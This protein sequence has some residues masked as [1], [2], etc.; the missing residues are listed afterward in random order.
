MRRGR[1]EKLPSERLAEGTFRKDL[2]ANK[3]ELKPMTRT[4][5]FIYPPEWLTPDGKIVWEENIKNC[6]PSL[7]DADVN[8]FGMFCNMMGLIQQCYKAG[9]RPS[10]DYLTETR[11]L[12]ELF[13]LCGARSRVVDN[14]ATSSS[15]N[16][17][18]NSRRRSAGWGAS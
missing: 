5:V 8:C 2:H 17:F 16:P 3:I 15:D 7:E 12:A 14:S 9:K 18:R 4:P 13:G 10:F 11:K 6:T 1:V